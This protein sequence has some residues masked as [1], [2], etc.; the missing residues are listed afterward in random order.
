MLTHE[1]IA[2][3]K[4]KTKYTS[5]ILHEHD[6]CIRIAYEWFDAQTKTK[7]I[8]KN[9]MPRP[10]K[11][12]IERWGGRYV[13]ESDVQV[14][15]TLHPEIKGEYPYYNISVKLTEPKRSRLLGIT[16]AFTHDYNQRHDPSSYKKQ[17][18]E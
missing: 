12:L 1:Q 17:E 11:H 7:T 8:N 5:E 16:E 6:D 18:Q 13:S 3:A 2:E 15:A 9:H 10:L 14:A 4:K